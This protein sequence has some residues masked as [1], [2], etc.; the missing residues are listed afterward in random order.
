MEKLFLREMELSDKEEIIKYINE[1]LAF[2]SNINGLSGTGCVTFE[3][4][5][6]KHQKNKEI[7]FIDYNQERGPQ[8]TYLLVRETDGKIVG[9]FN[10]RWHST[11]A[12]DEKFIGHIGYGIRPTERRKGYASQGLKLALD[13]CKQRGMEVVKLGCYTEN[14]G[15]KKTIIKNGG[16]LIKHEDSLCSQDYYEIKL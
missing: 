15:S 13:I 16:K 9:S 11:K 4:M 1:H 5:Y 7:K 14:I 12:V 3:E 6:E 8:A 10:I 2:G